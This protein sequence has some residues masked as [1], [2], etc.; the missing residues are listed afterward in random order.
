MSLFRADKIT[1]RTGSSDGAP[2]TLSGDSATMGSGVVFPAGHVIGV[3]TDTFTLSSGSVDI[4][5][6]GVYWTGLDVTVPATS[7]NNTIIV[8]VHIPG[9]TNKGV[10]G[11]SVLAGLR[12]SVDNWSN[13]LQLGPNSLV[14]QPAAY[15]GANVRE[16]LMFQ[17][18]V[19]VPTTSS[20]R[21]RVW[22]KG[23]NGDI[24][25]HAATDGVSSMVVWLI[26]G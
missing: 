13:V 14:V 2:I 21:I 9:V 19:A 11:R 25:I 4:V 24:E 8:Q 16:S 5:E 12:Y 1:G 26:Q 20:F 22:I 17:L 10:T 23:Q 3:Y 18:P 6:Q 15:V 7:T